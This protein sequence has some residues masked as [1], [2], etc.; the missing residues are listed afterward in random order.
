[1]SDKIVMRKIVETLENIVCRLEKQI[2]I[3]E[4]VMMRI[5][6]LEKKIKELEKK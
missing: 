1:M 4:L 5:N 3:D 6:A 2:E